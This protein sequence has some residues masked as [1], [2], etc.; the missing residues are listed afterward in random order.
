MKTRTF[1][2]R[3][4]RG[5]F[6]FEVGRDKSINWFE[7]PREAT[8]LLLLSRGY[9]MKDMTL[10]RTRGVTG[11]YHPSGNLGD[12]LVDVHDVVFCSRRDEAMTM[13][14]LQS[15]YRWC[16]YPFGLPRYIEYK[17]T[18]TVLTKHRKDITIIGAMFLKELVDG[19]SH[20]GDIDT[21]QDTVI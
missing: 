8:M 7:V 14:F 10:P 12:D 4:W 16:R 5:L 1:K 6:H 15:F 11:A 17:R 9:L 20:C 13:N 18:V 2:S 21:L 3:I 19:T